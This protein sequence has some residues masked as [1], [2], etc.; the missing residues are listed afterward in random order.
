[1][2]SLGEILK[3][4]DLYLSQNSIKQVY[5]S[6]KNISHF[7]VDKYRGAIAAYT[8]KVPISLAYRSGPLLRELPSFTER[9]QRPS[10][11]KLGYFRAV[12]NS[13]FVEGHNMACV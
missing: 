1:M 5:L 7:V 11:V 13:E 10:T 12:P 4:H 9:R 8:Y 3:A 6:F 2:N